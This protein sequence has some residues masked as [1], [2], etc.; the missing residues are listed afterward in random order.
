MLSTEDVQSLLGEKEALL[1]VQQNYISSD[2]TFVI[3]VTKNGTSMSRLDLN[4]VEIRAKI[5]ELRE[6]FDLT[7]GAESLAF[8]EPYDYYVLAKLL[9]GYFR[10]IPGTV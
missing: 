5:E 7:E 9:P 1:F 3:G 6:H 2:S 8:E 10:S 4:G